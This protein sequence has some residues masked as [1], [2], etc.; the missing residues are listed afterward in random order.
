MTES[1]QAVISRL[2]HEFDAL[3]RQ[4]SRV[5]G[6]LTQLD[7]LLSASE[8]APAPSPRPAPVFVPP[9]VTP[10]QQAATYWQNYW[11]YWQPAAAAPL[12]L[13]HI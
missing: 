12:S 4:L 10:Q 8:P 13:I 7:R 9:P 11:Q 2:S 5:S 6:E 3:A 1:H